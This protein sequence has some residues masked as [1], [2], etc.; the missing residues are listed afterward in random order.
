MVVVDVLSM[1]VVEVPS[2]ELPQLAQEEAA[3]VS[4][5]AGEEAAGL[6]DQSAQV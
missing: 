3:V 5:E 4:G 2:S 1:V 6:E